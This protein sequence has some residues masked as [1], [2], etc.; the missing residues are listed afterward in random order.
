M[1]GKPIQKIPRAPVQPIPAFEEPFS[2]VLLD[3]F[4]PLPKLK[5]GI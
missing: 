5:S 2:R 4:G 1:V 3:C